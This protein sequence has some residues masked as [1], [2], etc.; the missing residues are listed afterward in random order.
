MIIIFWKWKVWTSL[1]SLLKHIKYESILMDDADRDDRFLEKA[2]KIVVSPWVAQN[3]KLYKKYGNKTISELNFLDWI[4]K[5]NK[6]RQQIEFIAVTGTNWKSTSVHILFETMKRLIMNTEIHLS[7]NFGTP[8]SETLL[9]ILKNGK[10]KKHLII[11]ECSSFMLYKLKDFQFEYSIL[12][13][14]AKDHLD[15][16]KDFQEYTECKTTLLKNTIKYWITNQEIRNTLDKS[17][18]EKIAIYEGSYDLKKTQFLWKHN[19]SNRNAIEHIIKKY[20]KDHKLARNQQYFQEVIKKVKP[21]EHR[22]S[23]LREIRGIKIYDDGICTS[24]QALNAALS[25]FNEK[26]IFIAWGYD[27]WDDYTRLADEFKNKVAFACFIGKTKEKLNI[28]FDQQEI[29]YQNF[30]K[31]PDCVEWAYQIAKEKWINTILFSPGA[32]SFDMFN[33]VYDRINKF[34]KLVNKL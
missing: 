14:I 11:L 29:E 33:N 19:E 6:L 30:D 10:D 21:L 23:L 8:L 5:E 31:L 7:W 9:D 17:T 27:K 34:E 20:F 18:Q 12:T 24:S 3:H 26:I 32:A 28:I 13:N 16:H 25:C 1:V 22:M 2:D 4:I 15:R